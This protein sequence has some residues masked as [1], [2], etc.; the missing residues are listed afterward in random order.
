MISELRPY[1]HLCTVFYIQKHI[2]THAVP[3]Y[4]GTFHLA[5]TR[6]H[7][8]LRINAEH[9]DGRV[10]SQKQLVAR[11]IKVKADHLLRIKNNRKGD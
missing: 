3:N 1:R 5:G 7:S 10:T 11:H 9:T 8:T 4:P 6:A 2:R